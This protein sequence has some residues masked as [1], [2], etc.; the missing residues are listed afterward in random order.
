MSKNVGAI[1]RIIRVI[2][3]LILI[4]GGYSLG[5]STILGIILIVLGIICFINAITGFC[6]M[7]KIF[8]ISTAK[9]KVQEQS[10]PPQ[11]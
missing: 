11:S 6:L 7:Y 4:Y 3:G 10:I 8:G 1:D 5:A 9:P 2:V